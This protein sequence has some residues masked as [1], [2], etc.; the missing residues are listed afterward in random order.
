MK[1]VDANNLAIKTK[2]VIV[3]MKAMKAIQETVGANEWTCVDTQIYPRI[4]M[5]KNKKLWSWNLQTQNWLIAVRGMSFQ[6]AKEAHVGSCMK[7][8]DA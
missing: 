3:G 7:W 8:V 1:W 5:D 4:F 6:G 2:R